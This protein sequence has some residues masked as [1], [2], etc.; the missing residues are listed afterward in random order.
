VVSRP[1]RDPPGGLHMRPRVIWVACAPPSRMRWAQSPLTR[2]KVFNGCPVQARVP[3]RHRRPHRSSPSPTN[4]GSTTD[5]R[6]PRS[7]SSYV[8]TSTVVFLRGLDPWEGY[9]VDWIHDVISA[10]EADVVHGST[11]TTGHATRGMDPHHA[12]H[13]QAHSPPPR[14]TSSMGGPPP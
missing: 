1:S 5:R 9:H 11:A 6:R 12:H 7:P 8:T 2:S 4:T 3:P 14:R 10:V 13:L